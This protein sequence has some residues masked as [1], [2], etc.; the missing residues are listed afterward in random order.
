MAEKRTVHIIPM[1]LEVDRVLGGLKEFP[2]NSAIF[3][4]GTNRDSDI[5]RKARKNGDLIREKV[6]ATIDIRERELDIFDFYA[7][8]ISIV[9]LMQE[10]IDGGAEVFVNLSTGNRIVSSAA[11]LAC[12]MT[13]S[14]PYY[15]K[16][17]SYS[18]PPEN[19][20]LSKGVES[21]QRLPSVRILGPSSRGEAVLRT[22]SSMGG[23]VKYETSLIQPLESEKGFFDER[24]ETESRRSYLARKRAHLS[25][26]LRSLEKDGYIELTKR[27][28]Y[29][30][31][32]LTN[33]GKL[34][35]GQPMA[36]N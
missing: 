5:E 6:S 4:Y 31:V 11:L 12:Y 25:R 27:G 28:R 19:A 13:G 16:P 20:V 34:F 2:T 10:L 24:K 9:H 15:V 29:V 14:N 35:S 22:I 30:S 33:S 32:S 7:S 21:V 3:L 36:S 8:T 23:S 1:G 17:L 26:M 18:M